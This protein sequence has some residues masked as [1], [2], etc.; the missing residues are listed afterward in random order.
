MRGDVH[1]RTAADIVWPVV[2][3][4]TPR[5]NQRSFALGKGPADTDRPRAT[6]RNVTR[7]QD[8]SE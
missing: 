1:S 5:P 8:A 3:G 7:M 2:V 4:E 6:K